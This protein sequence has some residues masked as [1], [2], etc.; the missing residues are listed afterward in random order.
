MEFHPETYRPYL[1]GFAR[2]LL[3]NAGRLVKK[4]DAE[5]F[6]QDTLLLA[7]ERREQFRGNSEQEYKAWLHQI[8]ANRFLDLIRRELS[9]K[10]DAALE[11]TFQETI[12]ASDGRI[13]ALAISTGMSPSRDFAVGETKLAI[14]DALNTLPEDQRVAIEL[15]HL[16]QLTE[17]ETAMLMDKTKPAIAGLLRRGREALR[18]KLDQLE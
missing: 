13:Q 4:F 16:G 1:L 5:D 11:E 8:L 18:S 9:G 10:R 17:A 3:I 15:H 7:H 6:V 12:D 2:S 14:F